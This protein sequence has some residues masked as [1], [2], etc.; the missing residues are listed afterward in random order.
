MRLR[1]ATYNV[2]R[3]YGRDRRFDPE[4]IAR[5]L[6]ELDADVVA[7]QELETKRE[8]G[9]DLLERFARELG[10]RAFA[11]PTV[12]SDEA[13]YGNAL[14]SRLPARRV[15]TLD[16]STGRSEPR[17]AIDALLEAD[18]KPL[19]VIATHLGL[20]PSDRRHQV[21]TLLAR[22]AIAEHEFELL[23]GDLNEWL[24]WGRPLRWLRRR[25]APTPAPATF[26]A[27]R[28]CLAL[29]RMWMHPRSALRQVARHAS[30]LARIASDHLP[31]V[32]TLEL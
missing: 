28:P 25:F 13:S 27:R 18:G 10:A 12:L 29:D 5:V 32:G 8:H 9:L 30:P 11:G 15:D 17:G 24:L 22:F 20:L 31:L 7:L 21:R 16:L 14:L 3:C 2:H 6:A 1:V 19:R 26:P 4:R 23:L